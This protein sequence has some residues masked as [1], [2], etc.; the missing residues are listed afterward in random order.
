MIQRAPEATE[1]LRFTNF[2]SKMEREQLVFKLKR[3]PNRQS[4]CT[5]GVRS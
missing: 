4:R 5:L 1:N 3:F 2:E